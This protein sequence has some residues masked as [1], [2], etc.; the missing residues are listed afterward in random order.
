[1]TARSLWFPLSLGVAL[2]TGAVTLACGTED[3]ALGTTPTDDAVLDASVSSDA[4]GDEAHLV[5]GPAKHGDASTKDAALPPSGGCTALGPLTFHTQDAWINVASGIEV[6]ELNTWIPSLGQLTITLYQGAPLG[7]G[8]GSI[9][10]AC[11]PGSPCSGGQAYAGSVHYVVAKGTATIATLASPASNE[12][13]GAL[14]GL[15]LRAGKEVPVDGGV[16][17]TVDPKGACFT[18]G[19]TTFDTRAPLGM[20]CTQHTQCGTTKVCSIASRTCAASECTQGGTGCTSGEFCDMAR[21]PVGFCARACSPFTPCPAGYGC[22]TGICKHVGTAVLGAM[23]VPPADDRV[24]QGCAAGLLCMTSGVGGSSA[25]CVP[26]CDPFATNP[27][28]AASERCNFDGFCGPPQT[29]SAAALDQ[30][31][32]VPPAPVFPQP[33]T[34][35]CAD[36]G[37]AYRGICA[38]EGAVGAMC[39]RVCRPTGPPC[40]GGKSCMPVVSLLDTYVC[41]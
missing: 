39:R 4:E 24:V 12:M 3:T 23:C 37:K 7:F 29:S 9:S 26:A 25:K 17:Y 2:A 10:L 15:E 6:R 8:P 36:D 33:T 40:A 20:A 38:S 30:S 32:V 21:S 27:G 13:T 5:D 11:A 34:A 28:C 18:I 14:N 41:R 35:P 31:C 16:F 19:D 22:E 1:M